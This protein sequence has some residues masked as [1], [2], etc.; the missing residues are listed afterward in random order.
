MRNLHAKISLIILTGILISACDTTKRVPEGE[1]LLIKNEINVNGDRDKSDEVQNLLYQE[2][3]SSIL[4]YRLRLNLY[5]L[6]KTNPD[7]SFRARFDNDPAKYNR[8]SKVLSR[9]QVSRLGESFWYS[10]IHNFLKRTGEPP[11]ILDSTSTAKSLLRLRAH[12]YN[13]GY[14]N[15]KTANVTDSVAPKKAAVSYSVITGQ[16][17]MLDSLK[18][19]ISTPVLDSIFEANKSRTLLKAG[20]QYRTE[21]FNA[22]KNRV[23]T[24]FRNNGIFHFQQ[25][26]VHFDIDTVDTNHKAHSNMI[27]DEYSYREN[28]STKTMPFKMFRISEVNIFTDIDAGKSK[29]QI[30]DSAT[31]NN[32]NIYSSTKLKYRARAL[33]DAVFI[34]QGNLF[35]DFR[36]TLTSRYLSNLR[37]FNYPSIQ[38]IVDPKDSTGHSLVSNIYLAPRKKFSFGAGLDVTHSNIQDFGIALTTSVSI[39]NIFNGAEILEVSGRGNIGSSR[40]LANP[41]DNFFNVSEYGIDTKLIF[42]RILMPFNTDKIIPKNM[43]PVT[44]FNV[45]FA[46]Q[47]NIGLDKENFTSSLTY[48][49]IPKRFSTARFDLFNVQYVKNVNINNYFRVYSS[50][51][52]A[53]NDIAQ[54]YPVNPAYFDGENLEPEL[55]TVSFLND[56]GNGTIAV[57]ADD[58]NTVR[59]IDERRRRL[60]ENNLI[61]ASSY[62]FTKT[63][64]TDLQDNNFYSFK[65]KIESAGNVMALFAKVS[66]QLENQNGNNTIFDIEYSQY[67]KTE[68]EYIKHWDLRRQRVFAVRAF[69]GIAIP[70]GN[71]D[72]VPFSRSYFA[73]G[74]NDNRAWRSYGLGPGSSG[75]VNDFNEANMKLA[76]SAELRFNL[77]GDLFGA[78]FTDVGNIWNVL[79]DVTDPKYTFTG[80]RSLEDIAV[81]SGFGLRYDFNFFV[82]RLDMGFKTYN[83]AEQQGDKWFRDYNFANSVL[84]IGIN[85]P[86]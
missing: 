22:E 81:G 54:N 32:I 78:V 65:T 45:G 30:R 20:E 10:G 25:N 11:V 70:Y 21:D 47:Q 18:T 29:S 1:K 6:A 86:F 41:N 62:T 71:S 44:S 33:T 58:Q 19:S 27:I 3:N 55:G 48:N 17:Y 69:A 80:F 43:I 77:F 73:G 75:A 2:P 4:G 8:L 57:S 36:T 38:Y 16:P 82:V 37:V 59:S 34:N 67:I 12:Y 14:F 5:N 40:D 49:W 68:F 35:A 50:S 24:N 76:F 46:K 56:V 83:P 60:T 23:T 13:D 72:N 31:Y 66:R 53:L 52:D 64:K 84:N 26:Y 51:Y 61:V 85:Y 74:S 9:K 63:T 39:R 79:D 7:S 15:V 42:P 28:D